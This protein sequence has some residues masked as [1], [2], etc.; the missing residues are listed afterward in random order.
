MSWLD[1][2]FGRLRIRVAGVDLPEEGALNFATG[3][4]G[5]DNPNAGS[6]DIDISGSG[7][8]AAGGDLSGTYPNPSVAKVHGATAPSAGALTTGNVLKVSG[9]SALTYG[10]VN[11]AGGANHV[12]GTL[13]TGNQ[14]AQSMGGD[15][16]GNTGACTVAKVNGTTYPAGGSLTTGTIPR[17]TGAATVAYGA[18]DLA[19]A[20]AV[21][22][23]LPKTNQAAQ[24]MG[25]DCSGTTAACV[26][27]KVNG[28]TYGAGGSL[29]TGQVPRV[30]GASTTAYGALDLANTNAV[31]GV[32]PAANVD[33]LASGAPIA[34]GT[35]TF[36]TSNG[37][38]DLTVYTV[39]A[40]PSGNARFILTYILVRLKT[41]I[42]GGGNVV[43]RAGTTTGGNELLV[44]SAAW[45]SGTAAGTM[46]GLDISGLGASFTSANGYAY[47]AAASATFKVRATTA[48]GGISGGDAECY[49][50]GYFLP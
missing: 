20:S 17:V 44:D 50:Y 11:L 37:T 19:N 25:G 41:A 18:L 39:P 14:A 48:G 30:T 34:H 32:L 45:T 36:N 9:A 26:V 2:L 24:D 28:T 29:T 1:T 35:L 8:G 4:T 38:A 7:G 33:P 42:T 27:A 3:A 6:T 47:S 40:S 10:A 43:V 13:P 22:G 16:S 15:C 46:I 5:T 49:V 23:T 21:T 12:A 31:T